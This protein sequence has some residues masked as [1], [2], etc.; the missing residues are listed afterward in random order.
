MSKHVGSC[1]PIA[2][3]GAGEIALR[4]GRLWIHL[5]TTETLVTTVADNES[6]IGVAC[7]KAYT[8][9]ATP[10]WRSEWAA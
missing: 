5:T 2:R 1:P 8:A 4:P 7:E 10:V 9:V 3:S 6:H